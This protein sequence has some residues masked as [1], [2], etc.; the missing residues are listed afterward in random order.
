M[1]FV[2]L[3]HSD[4]IERCDERIAADI[5]DAH[6]FVLDHDGPFRALSVPLDAE[7]G[8]PEGTAR[9]VTED[10]MD[11][12]RDGFMNDCADN[13]MTG[14]MPEPHPAINADWADEVWT[15]AVEEARGWESHIR[16][17]I[18]NLRA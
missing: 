5:Q 18:A 15:D 2:L 4:N 16:A 7:T 11:M 1:I 10:V 14:T 13:A 9:W 17:E 3:T 12:L 6:D 8:E